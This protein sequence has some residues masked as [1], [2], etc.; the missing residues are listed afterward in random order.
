[1]LHKNLSPITISNDKINSI[2]ELEPQVEMPMDQIRSNSINGEKNQEHMIVQQQME[3]DE[4]GKPDN[5]TIHEIPMDIDRPQINVS[6]IMTFENQS[7]PKLLKKIEIEFSPE[8][9]KETEHNQN[10]EQ[11]PIIQKKSKNNRRKKQLII[12]KILTLSAHEIKDNTIMYT[13]FQRCLYDEKLFIH[14]T[15]RTKQLN[16]SLIPL[17]ISKHFTITGTLNKQKIRHM[18]TRKVDTDNL[19]LNN[20]AGMQLINNAKNVEINNFHND[21]EIQSKKIDMDFIIE[22]KQNQSVTNENDFIINI[23]TET[24]IALESNDL[25][26][27]NDQS[28]DLLEQNDASE[29]EENCYL[30]IKTY[31]N[32]I[33]QNDDEKCINLVIDDDVQQRVLDEPII[34]EKFVGLLLKKLNMTNTIDSDSTI[35]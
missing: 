34:N 3:I 5:A 2:L 20:C 9:I 23:E 30:K 6:P 18:I 14:H 35:K 31:E 12:D 17:Q 24:Q 28:N 15:M 19:L 26:Q 16:K 22:E 10:N 21:N 27:K 29:K 33:V 7:P 4:F 8:N 25:L 11:P 1:M 13:Q 32:E